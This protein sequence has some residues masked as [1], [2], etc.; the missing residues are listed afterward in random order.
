MRDES[1]VE[2]VVVGDDSLDSKV[3]VES[4][5]IY[6]AAE[7]WDEVFGLRSGLYVFFNGCV[8]AMPVCRADP[9][10]NT[11]AKEGKV[12]NSGELDDNGILVSRKSV[13]GRALFIDVFCRFETGAIL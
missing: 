7:T 6:E 3:E 10:P 1:T 11:D 9:F 4:R 2:I 5:R 12:A 8:S 13:V